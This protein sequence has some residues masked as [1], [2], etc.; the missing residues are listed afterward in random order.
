MVSEVDGGADDAVGVARGAELT[1]NATL[2][3]V[4]L[5]FF[6]RLNSTYTFVT[7]GSSVNEYWLFPNQ[8]GDAMAT[9]FNETDGTPM[10]LDVSAAAPFASS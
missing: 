4:A 5:K 7:G 6:E 8:H 9:T 10:P 2:R 3:Q 1:S